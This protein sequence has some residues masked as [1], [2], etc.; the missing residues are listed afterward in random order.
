M[1]ANDFA[2]LRRRCR[3][4]AALYDRFRIDHLVGFFRTYVRRH[5]QRVDAR[6]RL[7]PGVFDPAEEAAQTS[8]ASA[9][10]AR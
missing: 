2:W 1:R 4:T 9:S 3:Y 8:T 7:A 6:G 10:S 5:D